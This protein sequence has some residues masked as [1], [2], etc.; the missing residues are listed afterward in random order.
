MYDITL[1]NRASTATR[2]G[3]T[4]RYGLLFSVMLI[5]YEVTKSPR[6]KFPFGSLSMGGFLLL[7]DISRGTTLACRSQGSQ[8]SAM[9]HS[10]DGWIDLLMR[11]SHWMGMGTRARILS[12]G[13]DLNSEHSPEN[14]QN[15]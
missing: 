2:S 6:V 13:E 9:D 14:P 11:A 3:T 4:E 7:F 8:R 15:K 12:A 5:A 1:G 10:A